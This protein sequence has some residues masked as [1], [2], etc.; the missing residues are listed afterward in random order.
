MI[1]LY[2]FNSRRIVE[3]KDWKV[4][5]VSIDVLPLS[6]DDNNYAELNTKYTEML[7]TSI[8]KIDWSDCK[9]LEL[10]I[11]LTIPIKAEDAQIYF[12]YLCPIV[13]K[14]LL[15]G[16]LKHKEWRL[17]VDNEKTK[18]HKIDL[19]YLVNYNTACDC[20]NFVM[21]YTEAGEQGKWKTVSAV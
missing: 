15:Q 20:F 21:N 18:F 6:L 7:T 4:R 8:S 12:D 14:M 11:N 10:T 16:G 13:C 19:L 2:N 3:L 5:Q 17:S 9:N 1:K